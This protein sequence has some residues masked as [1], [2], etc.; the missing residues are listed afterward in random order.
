MKSGDIEEM[1]KN[2]FIEDTLSRSFSH[3]SMIQTLK[4]TRGITR[5]SF[6]LIY[7]CRYKN[8][9]LNPNNNKKKPAAYTKHDILWPRGAYPESAGA[10]HHE[11]PANPTLL[12]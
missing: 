7:D 10:V 12:E 4:A 1:T 3:L 11:M 9:Q 5:M 2:Q 6:H 8:P